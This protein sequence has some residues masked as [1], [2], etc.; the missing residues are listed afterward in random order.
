MTGVKQY[1]DDNA[2]QWLL[3]GYNDD[4]Y[5]YPTAAHRV[6]IVADYIANLKRRNL[7]ILDV[8]CGG[9]NLAFRLASDEH[10]V[11][12]IDQSQ[13]MIDLAEARRNTL[14]KKARDNTTFLRHAVGRKTNFSK[15][16]DVV[17]AMGFIGYL[18]NDKMLFDIAHSLLKPNGYFIVSARN[19]LFNMQSISQRT[20][21]EIKKGE[22]ANLI[23]ELHGLYEN[24]P[25][26]DVDTFIRHFKKIAKRLPESMSSN[27]KTAASP[28]AKYASYVSRLNSEPRQ[29]TPEGLK[30]TATQCGF[31]HITY[32]GI[33]PHL[34]DPNV[35][36]MLP[37]QL[38]NQISGCL[39]AFEHLP[40]SLAWSSVI[41]GV[42]QK[43]NKRKRYGGK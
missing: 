14:P 36:K 16:F 23:K 33:H 27:Q 18:P 4:G 37:P 3:D 34:I 22:A 13:N 10:S 17:T 21:K 11:T 30:K 35:N 40:I 2:K 5:N 20:E 8:A 32:Y 28:S 15:Q 42:F 31:K 1:F 29:S 24:I 7:R 26:E 41:L 9:G 12:G 43:T 38:F 39:E 25:E 6:R 19:R